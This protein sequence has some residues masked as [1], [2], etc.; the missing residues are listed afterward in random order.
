MA[1]LPRGWN[2]LDSFL[3]TWLHFGCILNMISINHLLVLPFLFS[4]GCCLRS[5]AARHQMVSITDCLVGLDA[6]LQSKTRVVRTMPRLNEW[7]CLIIVF[8][9][10]SFFGRMSCSRCCVSPLVS[11]VVL[12]TRLDVPSQ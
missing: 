12:W 5:E 2:A 9:I 10:E 11:Y 3:G 8:I 4:T 6:I 7:G 1:T